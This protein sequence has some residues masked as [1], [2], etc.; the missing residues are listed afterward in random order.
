MG[1]PVLLL[2]Q[3]LE[4]T[5]DDVTAVVDLAAA[6]EDFEIPMGPIDRGTVAGYRFEVLGMVGAQ[7]LIALEHVTRIHP[8][9]APH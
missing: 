5:L 3:A 4:L 7:A 1:A 2:A 9:V 8:D 6:S